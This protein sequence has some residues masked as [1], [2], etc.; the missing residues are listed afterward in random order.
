[1]T[2]WRDELGSD[3]KSDVDTVDNRVPKRVV[4]LPISTR[5]RWRR[6]RRM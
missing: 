6:R 1:M 2:T 4:E 5:R 3:S